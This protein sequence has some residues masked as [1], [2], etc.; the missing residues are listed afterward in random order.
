MRSSCIP[1][2]TQVLPCHHTVTGDHSG[3]LTAA[4]IRRSLSKNPILLVTCAG[5]RAEV[6]KGQANG[7]NLWMAQVLLSGVRAGAR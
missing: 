6:S 2:T 5:S 7:P 1:T 3:I 4:E